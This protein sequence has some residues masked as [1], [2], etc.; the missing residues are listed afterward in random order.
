VLD[1]STLAPGDYFLRL[2]VSQNGV[3]LD[4]PYVIT[5]RIGGVQTVENP[6][7]GGEEDGRVV[8]VAKIVNPTVIEEQPQ[9]EES[10]PPPSA[11]PK[12]CTSLKGCD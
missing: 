8:D 7:P 1:A 2:S 3:T 5:V 6:A 11:P 10:A 4:D 12:S 9:P